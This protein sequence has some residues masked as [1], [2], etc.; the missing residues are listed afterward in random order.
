[1]EML[2]HF[3]QIGL[4]VDKEKREMEEAKLKA[5]TLAEKEQKQKGEQR[6]GDQKKIENDEVFFFC[7]FGC[8]LRRFLF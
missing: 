6:E 4:L 8:F 3:F 7:F 2:D 1:M 5:A